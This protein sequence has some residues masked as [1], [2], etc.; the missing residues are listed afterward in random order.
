MYVMKGLKDG[1]ILMFYRKEKL[2]TYYP[3]RKTIEDTQ[4]FDR[5]FSGMAY[6][7]SFIKLQ[8]FELEE[9]HVF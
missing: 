6:R 1:T 5:Y 8:N 9:V 4:I 2:L 7:P 3:R